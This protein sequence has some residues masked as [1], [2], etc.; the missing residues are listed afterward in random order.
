MFLIQTIFA[1]G[2]SVVEF[3]FFKVFVVLQATDDL[4]FH[5]ESC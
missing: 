4:Q 5:T 1:G 2:F 3:F